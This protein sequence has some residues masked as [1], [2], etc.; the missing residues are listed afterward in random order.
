VNCSKTT[1]ALSDKMCCMKTNSHLSILLFS[2]LTFS[3][4]SY[5]INPLLP[6]YFVESVENG[7]LGWSRA[8][9]FTLFG[10]LLG[11]I[12][13]SP[14]L[15]GL[16]GDCFLG[17]PL[18]AVLGYVLFGAGVGALAFA[19]TYGAVSWAVVGIGLG[20]GCVKV[21]LTAIVGRL[22]SELRKKGYEYHFVI[23]S[24]G[25][26]LGGLLS[27]PLFALGTIK[28]VVLCCLVAIV[29]SLF[30]FL[31][32]SRSLGQACDDG[33]GQ[34]PTTTQEVSW[35]A[36]FA[37]LGVGL[38]FFV[39]SN[40]LATGMPV[41][42]H[43]CV[44]RT[45]GPWTIPAPWFGVAGSIV[46]AFLSPLFRRRWAVLELSP[47]ALEWRKL[48]IGFVLS[49]LAFAC[50][51]CAALFH[52]SALLLLGVHIACFVADFHV[53][54]VLYASATAFTPTRFHTLSTAM[55]FGCIGL[56]GKLSGTL[57]SFVDEMGFA[58]LFALC[59]SV[60]ALCALLLLAW[61]ARVKG[62]TLA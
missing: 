37:R 7:G 27:Y 53:R 58:A 61:P 44:D 60:A 36:F 34:R 62:P 4:A 47:G 31:W 5:L 50:A 56:G 30:L 11:F 17:R 19:K 48:T 15:G 23:S 21:S 51:C 54:P 3:V 33:T 42:L 9:A 26:A 10:T 8:E 22:K 6:I 24:L 46:M 16:L 38:P 55:V 39:C 59:S 32:L 20:I 14:F 25:F 12:Y 41:F 29:T 43:Q 40:Q 49:A 45:V 13:A 28:G 52:L 57:A 1:R 35:G 18:T 2:V